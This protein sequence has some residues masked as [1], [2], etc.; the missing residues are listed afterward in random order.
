[1]GFILFKQGTSTI[2]KVN[3]VDHVASSRTHRTASL[4]LSEANETSGSSSVKVSTS[5]PKQ[6]T[7]SSHLKKMSEREHKQL[8]KKFS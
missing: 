5:G 2:K 1:M 3:F 4:Q 6:T 8:K 7:R